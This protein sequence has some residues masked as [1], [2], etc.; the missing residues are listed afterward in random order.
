[1]S[2]QRVPVTCSYSQV[3][4]AVGTVQ[5]RA[6]E[7]GTVVGIET[8]GESR[9]SSSSQAVDSSWTE[10]PRL[11]GRRRVRGK[12]KTRIQTAADNP[13]MRLLAMLTLFDLVWTHL[14]A[15]PPEAKG[16]A[17]P[18]CGAGAMRR[19]PRF[20][21]RLVSRLMERPRGN[22]ARGHCRP[23]NTFRRIRRREVCVLENP[24]ESVTR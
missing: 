12:T 15:G 17:T 18:E 4:V 24:A 6:G 1:V 7:G 11:L 16:R 5:P 9:G 3:L 23:S 20:L 13:I 19:R 2:F 22:E 14:S 10:V 8:A 21:R